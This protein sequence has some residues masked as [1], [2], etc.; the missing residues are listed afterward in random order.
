M[1][2][3]LQSKL[4]NFSLPARFNL[5]VMLQLATQVASSVDRPSTVRLRAQARAAIEE[6][7][8]QTQASALSIKR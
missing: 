5:P 7:S 1:R 3:A 4:P 6:A 2:H 8:I